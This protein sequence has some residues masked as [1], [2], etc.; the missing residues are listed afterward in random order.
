[1]MSL[2]SVCAPKPTARPRM[3]APV[4]IGVMS[5][6]SSRS[7][8]SV[9]VLQIRTE[10]NR[11][12]GAERLRRLRR[13]C[14]GI[15]A[16]RRPRARRCGSPSR[17]S[18]WRQRPAGGA[19]GCG[20]RSRATH[21]VRSSGCKPDRQVDAGEIEGGEGQHQQAED[22]GDAPHRPDGAFG[23]RLGVETARLRSTAAAGGSAPPTSSA[24]AAAM[25]A[26]IASAATA[27]RLTKAGSACWRSVR[28]H[29]ISGVGRVAP[30]ALR[31]GCAA[32]SACRR[33]GSR[34]ARSIRCG[35][36]R[37]RARTATDRRSPCR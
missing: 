27:S 18:G 37:S 10:T 3:P 20:R 23:E 32:S 12:R 17:R 33:A 7:I 22:E 30:A 31:P 11:R 25:S 26:A 1:M 16:L 9:A 36:R 28:L 8:M 13:S 21:C 4:R 34:C 2:T 19:T 24:I 35:C 14:L 5:T 6:S 29:A 15:A